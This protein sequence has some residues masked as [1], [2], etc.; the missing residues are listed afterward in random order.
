MPINFGLNEIRRA[1]DAAFD[2]FIRA[3]RTDRCASNFPA[4]KREIAI[5]DAPEV[6]PLPK[7]GA[8]WEG[9]E[10]HVGHRIC[11]GGKD[12]TRLVS[13]FYSQGCLMKQT[14]IIDQMI[15]NVSML[16][17]EVERVVAPPPPDAVRRNEILY[18][19]VFKPE[20]SFHNRRK[21][22]R[23][24]YMED[25][26]NFFTV[27]ND[28]PGKLR[29]IVHWCWDPVKKGPCC[30]DDL[31]SLVKCVRADCGFGI[32]HGAPKVTIGD[33]VGRVEALGTTMTARAKGQLYPRAFQFR[34]RE[35]LFTTRVASLGDLGS[36]VNDFKIVNLSRINTLCS[37]HDDP[38]TV[39]SVP[40]QF[41]I[42]SPVYRV[43]RIFMSFTK[44]RTTVQM[45]ALSLSPHAT[46]PYRIRGY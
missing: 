19:A 41:V 23:S 1:I 40:L 6:E 35:E 5:A 8:S 33:F 46:N 17:T 11:K 7:L 45:V 39:Y 21:K 44:T 32:K 4:V 15:N 38:T 30:K 20:E 43:C 14:S 12:A 22:S 2:Y 34:E 27:K 28:T 24:G 29:D 37:V 42:H 13:M 25:V 26:K 10:G 18:N 16:N 9:C 31:E 36:G 3:F